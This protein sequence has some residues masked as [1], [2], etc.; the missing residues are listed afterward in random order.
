MN[1]KLAAQIVGAVLLF[2]VLFM[3]GT[4]TGSVLWFFQDT[5][6][7]FVPGINVD[8]RTWWECVRFAWV[9]AM[10]FKGTCGT[11]K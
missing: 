10:L 8:Q 7:L 4:L 5:V 1:D 9:C 6:A 3:I 2:L 11:T